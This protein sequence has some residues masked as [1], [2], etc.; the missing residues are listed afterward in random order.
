MIHSIKKTAAAILV[1]ALIFAITLSLGA[2]GAGGGGSADKSV[3][4]NSS[5]DSPRAPAPAPAPEA[6]MPAMDGA[7]SG[8]GYAEAEYDDFVA[9]DTGFASSADGV[10]KGRKITFRA[11]MS[12][13]TKTYDAD[14]AKINNLIVKAGGYVSSENT[15]DYSVYG[16]NQGRD[17]WL[18]ARIPAEG[19]DSFLD[20]LSEVGDVSNKSKSSDDLTSQYF[21]TEARIEMLE[22]RKERLMAYLV[23]AENAADIVE[24]ER[25]LSGVLYDLDMYQGNKRNLDQLVEFATVDVSLV[26]LITPETIGK[27]GEPLGERATEAFALSA[28]GVVRFLQ[29]FVVFLAGAAPVIALLVIV[30]VIIW[31]IVRATRPLREK[32]RKAREERARNSAR[33]K[34]QAY[35]GPYW[36]QGYQQQPYTQPQGYQEQIRQAAPPAPAEPL[37]AEEPAAADA[38]AKQADT[39]APDADAQQAESAGE[40]APETEETQK[41]E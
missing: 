36:Q 34:Q 5:A 12:I 27:D 7:G 23:E 2:C 21:D 40:S 14:Y 13:N 41:E 19:F 10:Q 8:G 38:D 35:G 30:L 11:S 37:A 25:E 3:F 29:G 32:S 33:Q 28:D 18:S 22:L 31:V 9:M 20:K 6:S 16:R 24:F 1:I 15:N 26:E 4:T 39:S 17:T